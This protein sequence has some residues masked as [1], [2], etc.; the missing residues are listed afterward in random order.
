LEKSSN[1]ERRRGNSIAFLNLNN[2]KINIMI[3]V[4][5]SSIGS[6]TLLLHSTYGNTIMDVSKNSLTNPHVR[7][8]TMDENIVD[9]K[10]S[11][12]NNNFVWTSMNG[13]VNPDLELKSGI[14]YTIQVES[15]DNNNIAHQLII[16]TESGKQVTKS[17]EISNGKT[18]D[19][20]FTF[21]EIGK[22]QY[23]CQY[24]PKTMYGNIIVS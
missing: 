3:F 15:M 21:I 14:P 7:Y 19:F 24:H 13:Q 23:H 2:K 22:Y 12:R 5:L 6:S 1:I 11:E 8:S 10:V 20:L 16:Q 4:L 18:D 9:L 17:D